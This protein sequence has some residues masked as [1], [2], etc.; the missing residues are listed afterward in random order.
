MPDV[1]ARGRTA[2][3]HASSALGRLPGPSGERSLA[4]FR[5][6][7][8]TVKLYAPRGHDPQTPHTLDEVYMIASGTGVF[9][10]GTTRQ[11]FGPG[12]LIF[13]AA[14]VPHH[15]EDFTADLAVW[16]M[17]YGPEGGEPDT[18]T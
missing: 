18:A 7:T 2:H 16:V 10:D 17:F 6:G 12:D 3:L 1:V 4:L 14:G 8:L 11:P 15:F 13:V 9:F 5:H